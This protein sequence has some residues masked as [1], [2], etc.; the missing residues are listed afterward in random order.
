MAKNIPGSSATYPANVRCP[1]TGDAVDQPAWENGLTDLANRTAYLTAQVGSGGDGVLAVR[2]VTNPTNLKALT[3]M[4]AGDLCMV[5]LTGRIYI[6]QASEPQITDAGDSFEPF[7]YEADDATGYWYA[8]PDT[9]SVMLVDE[10]FVAVD[11]IDTTIGTYMSHTATT[12]WTDITDGADPMSVTLTG[13][14]EGDIVEVTGKFR[15]SGDLSVFR[16]AVR[17]GATDYEVPGSGGYQA[18][19]GAATN[20]NCFGRYEMPSA[21]ASVDVVLQV[22]LDSALETVLIADTSVMLQAKLY[23]KMAL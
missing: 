6:F 1:T 5:Q 16:A 20:Q 10:Q 15:S 2:S 12:D 19:A 18:A 22:K 14:M 23:R 21:Q 17:F 4:A 13:V 9:P 8:A 7:A 11:A 3:G